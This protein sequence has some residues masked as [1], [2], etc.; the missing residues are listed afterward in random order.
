[1]LTGIVWVLSLE[2]LLLERSSWT[3]IRHERPTT[4][5]NLHWT[6]YSNSN[7]SG[8]RTRF[9]SIIYHEQDMGWV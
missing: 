1:M 4:G 7:S 5:G 8:D 6:E 9:L 2:L 3:N